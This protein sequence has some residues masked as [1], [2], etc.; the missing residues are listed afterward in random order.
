MKV[1]NKSTETNDKNYR[2]L[3]AGEKLQYGDEVD[4]VFTGWHKI[5]AEHFEEGELCFNA[6]V[7][8][9]NSCYFPEGYYRRRVEPTPEE[10]YNARLV[11]LTAPEGYRFLRHG[12]V[13]EA[14]DRMRHADGTFG[15]IWEGSIIPG[16]RVG[17]TAG[18]IPM[19]SVYEEIYIRS[20][21]SAGERT[22]EEACGKLKVGIGYRFV[23]YKETIQE[24][25]SGYDLQDP[26]PGWHNTTHAGSTP[27]AV[28]PDGNTVYRRLLPNAVDLLRE[29]LSNQ[30]QENDR[31]TDSL[32]ATQTR[33]EEL[34]EAQL[35]DED[36][37]ARLG[38][39]EKDL[40]KQ[41]EAANCQNAA[42][43]RTA[44]GNAVLVSKDG[45]S[46]PIIVTTLFGHSVPT[47]RVVLNGT[48]YFL[49][50]KT[51][52]FGRAIFEEA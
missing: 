50:S 44:Y 26:L 52:G 38:A 13:I 45:W 2:L 15:K 1:Q 6:V 35:V 42:M 4:E 3:K 22:Y 46:R 36:T 43:L 32:R 11:G 41:L 34:L 39:Q 7:Q 31:L 37:I 48:D 25:D 19:Q 10:A 5:E 49:T 30:H 27:S 51:D 20:T 40:R 18:E 9:A 12:E 16:T 8:P 47:D 28:W 24:G 33:C 21:K 17:F 23:G 14:E 29:E